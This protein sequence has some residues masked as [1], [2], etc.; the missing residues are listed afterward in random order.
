MEMDATPKPAA[1][2]ALEVDETVFEPHPVPHLV[3]Q[4]Q[5]GVGDYRLKFRLRTRPRIQ[6]PLYLTALRVFHKL[7]LVTVQNQELIPSVF[8]HINIVGKFSWLMNSQLSRMK[9]L[10]IWFA[11]AW[12]LV[13]AGLGS[14][15]ATC[16]QGAPPPEPLTQQQPDENGLDYVWDFVQEMA[17]GFCASGGYR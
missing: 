12:L 7:I 17:Y 3:Q 4:F 11:C 9:K 13:I 16:H 14:G 10:L 1:I 6:R 8:T 15:C 5:L 2:R